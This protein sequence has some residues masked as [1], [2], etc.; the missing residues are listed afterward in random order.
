[1]IDQA[2]NTGW[3]EISGAT[4]KS[5]TSIQDLFHNTWLAHYPRPQLFVFENGRMGKFKS[6]F[7]QICDNDGIKAINPNQHQV[8]TYHLQ[9][10]AIIE[11]VHKVVDGK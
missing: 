5:S 4:N 2:I 1:M 11:R 7:K 3:F 6:E 9:T 8:T 10:N